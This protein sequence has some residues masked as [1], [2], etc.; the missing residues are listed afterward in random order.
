MGVEACASCTR[1]CCFVHGK[2][3]SPPITSFFKVMFG[4]KFDSTLFLPYKFACKSSGLVGQ[5]VFLED[6]T[7][8]QWEVKISIVDD[9]LA[10]Q[11]GWKKFSEDHNLRVGDFVVF[12]HTRESQFFVNI[13]G[14]SGCQKV[15]FLKRSHS[16]K[17]MRGN[18]SFVAKNALDSISKKCSSTLAPSCS[19]VVKSRSMHGANDM[20]L[21]TIFENT[22]SLANLNKNSGLVCETDYVEE[23]CYMTGQDLG[24]KQGEDK[25][26]NFDLSL[27][28]TLNNNSGINR[29]GNVSA[30]DKKFPPQVNSS[31]RSQNEAFGIGKNDGV[32]E[33]ASRAAVPMDASN[34][35]VREKNDYCRDIGKTAVV[36]DKSSKENAEGISSGTDK[37][38][39]REERLCDHYKSSSKSQNEAVLMDKDPVAFVC[40][41]KEKINTVEE[42]DKNLSISNFDSHAPR[43]PISVVVP[44]GNGGNIS[45]KSGTEIKEQIAGDP[46]KKPSSTYCVSPFGKHSSTKYNCQNAEKNCSRIS[47]PFKIPTPIGTQYFQT[48]KAMNILRNDP[49]EIQSVKCSQVKKIVKEETVDISSEL[50]RKA[51]K[52][53]KKEPIEIRRSPRNHES[54]GILSKVPEDRSSL[55]VVKA[56]IVDVVGTSSPT[57]SDISTWLATSSHQSFIE[58]PGYLSI[59]NVNMYSSNN[60]KGL[61]LLRDEARR[62]WPVVYHERSSMKVLSSSWEVLCRE[63]GIQPGDQCCFTVEDKSKGILSVRVVG[64]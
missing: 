31:Q 52:I 20:K 3:S 15:D 39:V 7:G 27:F 8:K 61:V 56:E 6:S 64:K 28:E 60:E 22:S 63:N 2:K 51:R 41:V 42:M 5:K 23:I 1:I 46:N 43:L 12:Y 35:G 49:V 9:S 24:G 13:Y 30:G 55:P 16:G 57:P 50:P 10:F 18:R 11:E 54:K 40:E 53:I 17:R 48:D 29:I 45:N 38:F 47:E 44:E 34:F 4:D 21:P 19:N 26:R 62:L 14:K 33:V 36:P 37:V 25:Q 32:K 59:P 58:L